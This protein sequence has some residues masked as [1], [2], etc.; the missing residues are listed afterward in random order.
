M[1]SPEFELL[2]ENDFTAKFFKKFKFQLKF[3]FSDEPDK[4]RLGDRNP[5]TNLDDAIAQ[6]YS[7]I[8][9]IRHPDYKSSSSYYDIALFKMN[10]TIR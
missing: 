9:I 8:E 1:H 7:I 5:F 4:I 10:S 6:E 3:H 2:F